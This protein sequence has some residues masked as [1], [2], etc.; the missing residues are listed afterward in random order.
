D[1]RPAQG[2]VLAPQLDRQRLSGQATAEDG[3]GGVG[4]GRGLRAHPVR[5]APVFAEGRAANSP[6]GSWIT[7]CRARQRRYSATTSPCFHTWATTCVV[8][9]RR[10]WNRRKWLLRISSGAPAPA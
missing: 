3:D 2:R 10:S 7:G 5:S 8:I 9:R 1:P 6:S 4:R